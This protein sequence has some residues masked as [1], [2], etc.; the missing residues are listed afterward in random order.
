MASAAILVGGQARRF[1]G[2]DKSAFVVGGRTILSRQLD[3]LSSL[4]DDTMI[5]G[6]AAVARPGVRVAFDRVAG[7]GPLA[8]VEAA[9]A[10]ARDE[11]VLVLACDMPFVTTAFLGY[12][13]SLAPDA[14]AIVPRTDRGYHPLCAVYSRACLDR[15]TRRLTKGQL[16]LKG[17]LGDLQVQA[18]G[19]DAIARYGIAERLLA[20][21]NTPADFGELEALPD[22]EP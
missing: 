12:L 16:A 5:V 21:V 8:G 14:E 4:C 1:G 22:H 20:N 3:A 15:V 11:H 13:L 10:A 6:P 18:V 2:R 7:A 17:L 19:R 9:L